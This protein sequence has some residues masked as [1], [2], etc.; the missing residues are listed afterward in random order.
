MQLQLPS[1]PLL[2]LPCPLLPQGFRK[3]C[4]LPLISHSI[5]SQTWLHNRPAQ[6]V[7]V[8]L[9][10]TYRLR[11]E[12]SYNLEGDADDDSIYGGAHDR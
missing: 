7:Y 6:D 4:P 5:T 2:L 11:M 9:I 8:L 3:D 12:D 1:P 10:D